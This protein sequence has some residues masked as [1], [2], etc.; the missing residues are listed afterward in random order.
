MCTYARIEENVNN[1]SRKKKYIYM[2]NINNT[3]LEI[4]S[5]VYGI[6]LR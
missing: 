2:E 5:S 6:L 4:H 1:K 3:S